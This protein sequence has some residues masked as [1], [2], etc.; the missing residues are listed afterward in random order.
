MARIQS[1][2]AA[3]SI[4]ALAGVTLIAPVSAN[5]GVTNTLNVSPTTLSI[6]SPGTAVFT[7]T[8]GSV[9]LAGEGPSQF[10]SNI[11]LAGPDGATLTGWLANPLSGV[12]TGYLDGS[13]NNPTGIV[14][15]ITFN[16]PSGLTVG[17]AYVGNFA[18][19]NVQHAGA[20]FGDLIGGTNQTFAIVIADIPEPGTVAFGI[21][22]AGSVLGLIARRRKA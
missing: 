7:V 15:T 13:I 18:F 8:A 20:P 3:F 16:I 4:A 6:T 14:N 2:L 21:I 12:G 11:Q 5:P 19:T 1:F 10:T 17:T 22:A 9:A